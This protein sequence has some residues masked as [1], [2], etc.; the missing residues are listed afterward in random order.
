METTDFRDLHFITHLENLKSILDK[1]ILSHDDAA[2]VPHESIAMEEVQATRSS[3]KLPDGS[4]LHAYAN[5]Y[6]NARNVM[7]YVRK[8]AHQQIGVLSVSKQ[9]L[10]FPGV[11]LTDCNA[12]SGFAK[13][14]TVSEILPELSH[15]EIFAHSWIHRDDY[16]ATRRHRARMCA[17]VLVP[18]SIPPDFIR[19]L[20]LSC[21][22][23]KQA[24]DLASI[25][26]ATRI[27]SDKFFRGARA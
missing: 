16:F 9:I 2:N 20:Y 15:D 26:I 13:F 5:V 7:M 22:L 1:G 3:V 27:D 18:N 8:D 10:D 14:G 17:E 6:L 23:S 19:G 21:K 12:A 24:V 25:E 11:I 4:R